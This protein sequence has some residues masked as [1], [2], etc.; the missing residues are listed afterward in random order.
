MLG[1][2]NDRLP[3]MFGLFRSAPYAD[4]VLG[5]LSRSRGRWRG[6]VGLAGKVVP[7]ALAGSRNAPDAVALAIAKEL[8]GVWAENRALVE[9]ALFEHYEPYHEAVVSGELDPPAALMLI[10]SSSDVWRYVDVQSASITSQDSR[11]IA[12]VALAVTWDEEHLLGARF[13][14]QQFTELNGSIIPE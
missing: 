1:N 9:K 6:E 10:A 5:H 3:R 14:R 4:P 12:E 8:A 7:L 11:L 2:T 13:N